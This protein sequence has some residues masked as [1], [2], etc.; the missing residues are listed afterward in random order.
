MKASTPLKTLATSFFAL[1]LVVACATPTPAPVS[2]SSVLQQG[3][4]ETSMNVQKALAQ[5]TIID[6]GRGQ[7][8]TPASFKLTIKAADG[9][10]AVKA[11]S[12]GTR[13]SVAADISSFDV[14]LIDSVAAPSG[15][16]TA[17]HGPFN[18]T[19]SLVTGQQTITFNNVTTSTN[20]YYV[21]IK[22]KDSGG[23]NITNL[24]SG[25]TIGGA[26]VYVSTTGGGGAG[27][28]GVGAAPTYTVSSTTQLG[29]GLT[30]LDALGATIDS[31]VTVTDGST[32]PADPV[33]AS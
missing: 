21:A 31:K 12:S 16:I 23:G 1:S 10:F 19:A 26:N 22:A 17:A 8:K 5:P 18:V 11:S 13:N 25:I 30:L 33:S 28:V 4:Q 14:Y 15:A 29:V 7:I 6:V 24:G 27:E 32:A 9:G 20:N 2:V 3:I